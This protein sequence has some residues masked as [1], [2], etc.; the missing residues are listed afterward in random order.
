MEQ[1]SVRF[2]DEKTLTLIR[3]AAELDDRSI[4][5]FIVKYAA[6]AAE[7]ILEDRNGKSHSSRRKVSKR[8]ITSK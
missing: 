6:D 5:N 8:R 7:R 4:T 2:K 3:K 1:I